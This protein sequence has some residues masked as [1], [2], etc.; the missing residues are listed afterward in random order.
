MSDLAARLENELIA[1][2]HAA[3]RAA[4]TALSLNHPQT[5]ALRMIAAFTE[6]L[7]K[8]SGPSSRFRQ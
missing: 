8:E 6:R 5:E 1:L 7:V 4:A 2:N 3:Q